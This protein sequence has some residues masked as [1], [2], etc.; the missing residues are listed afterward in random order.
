MS[1]VSLI[2]K[3]HSQA[4]EASTRYKKA[5]ADLIE[6][7][8]QVEEHRVYLKR[9]HSS[10]FSYVTHEL[11][12]AESTAYTLITVARKAREVP[13]LK[14]RIRSGAMTISNARRVTSV[15][16]LEN[17]G[18]WIQKASALSA[19]QLEKEIVKVRPQQATPERV[20]YVNEDRLKLEIGLSEKEVLK[21]RRVQDLMSQ[22]RKRHVT[23]E[24]TIGA[25][26]SDTPDNLITL[27]SSHHKLMHL[28]APT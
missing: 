27:C 11:G 4:L 1:I 25:L 22:S 10:L 18:E 28:N 3:I 26:T 23:L 5:E 17:Q 15:L 9:G 19:R 8:Q 16:T 7:L 21:L 14:D 2:D 6:I 13:A 20:R 24:E 12:L